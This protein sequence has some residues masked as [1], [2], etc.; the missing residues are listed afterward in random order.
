MIALHQ[1]GQRVKKDLGA[2]KRIDVQAGASVRDLLVGIKDHGR[3]SAPAPFAAQNAAF[4]GGNRPG[5]HHDANMPA[6]QDLQGGFGGGGGNHP[7]TRMRQHCIANGAQHSLRRDGQNGRSHLSP[8]SWI[9]SVFNS[10]P[11]GLA[12]KQEKTLIDEEN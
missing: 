2:F 1:R 8:V 5:D 4:A 12:R 6:T 9:F 11:G 3:D 7:I 10:I